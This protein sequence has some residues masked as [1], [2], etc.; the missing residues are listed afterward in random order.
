[1]PTQLTE[2]HISTYS[3]Y[4]GKPLNLVD[5]A[6]NKFAPED[7]RDAQNTIKEAHE[8]VKQWAIGIRDRM[9]PVGTTP[10]KNIS[11]TNQRGNFRDYLPQT[12]QPT[13]ESPT[14]I[15]YWVSK[16]IQAS[17]TCPYGFVTY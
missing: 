3:S 10:N 8:F 2:K 14:V 17:F 13:Q 5:G 4:V 9:F 15:S 11:A 12:F 16:K 6:G 7:R 1:M